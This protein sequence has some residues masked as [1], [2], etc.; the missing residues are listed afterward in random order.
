MS[1]DT[2]DLKVHL[3]SLNPLG[4]SYG[5]QAVLVVCIG[6]KYLTI[7]TRCIKEILKQI[8]LH[9]RVTKIFGLGLRPCMVKKL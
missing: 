1:V 2:S 4:K 9:Y 8:T 3:H 6:N 7:V 5:C